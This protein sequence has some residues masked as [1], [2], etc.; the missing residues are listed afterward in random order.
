M[1]AVELLGPKKPGRGSFRPKSQ[2]EEMKIMKEMRGRMELA[3][4]CLIPEP[5]TNAWDRS[6]MW[7]NKNRL[8]DNAESELLKEESNKPWSVDEKK[9]F[10][11]K[12]I[13][14]PKVSANAL[15]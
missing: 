14:H 2:Y 13:E 3:E 5:C 8:V 4:M 15:R 9:V 1:S 7:V 6:R 11:D 10:M 12:F